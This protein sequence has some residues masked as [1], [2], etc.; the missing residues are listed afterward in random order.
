MFLDFY[1]FL[2]TLH[3]DPKDLKIPPPGGWPNLMPENCAFFK[4]DYTIEVLRNLP[5]LG[6][7]ADVHYKS[8]LVDYSVLGR[9]Y[10]TSG[11]WT[12]GELSL[13]A[14]GPVP[15]HVVAIAVG[16]ESGGRDLLLDVLQGEIIEEEIRC[17]NNG[18]R[19][20]QEY[21]DD[22]KEAFRSLKL[23][24]C[25]D[26]DMIEATRVEERQG[27]ITREEFDGQARRFETDL[28]VQYL[29]QIYCQHGWPEAFRRDEAMKIIA[30]VRDGK[31]ERE[32]GA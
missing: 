26:W 10:F 5:Y 11:P 3:F 2:T 32:F 30:E 24:P 7:E 15:D 27:E 8:R 28:D 12:H 22:L 14:D 6:G 21:L 16:H 4:T 19:D 18:S 29:R 20:V 13:S 17:Q 31:I 25:P 23:L 1:K 9:E